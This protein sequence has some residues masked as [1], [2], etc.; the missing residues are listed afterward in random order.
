MFRSSIRRGPDGTVRLDLREEERG[1][2]RQVAGE[3]RELLREEPEDPVASAPLPD[4]PRGSRR[5]S[6]TTA[7]SHATSW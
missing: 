4:R 7:S 5:G 2:L 6:A 3:L 1:L